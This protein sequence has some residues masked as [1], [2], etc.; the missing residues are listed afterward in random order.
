[1]AEIDLERV[2]CSLA[3][4]TAEG[5]RGF[6]IGAGHWPLRGLV[7][8]TSAGVVAAYVNRCPHAGHGLNLRPH[9]FLTPDGSLIVC[10][11]HGA[12]FEKATGVCVAGPCVGQGLLPVPV[13]VADGYVLLAADVDPS[14]LVAD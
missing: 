11:S 7:V 1:M 3:E 12:V 5:C 8:Q 2:L 13:T 9:K 10:S 6:T 4:L 14:I